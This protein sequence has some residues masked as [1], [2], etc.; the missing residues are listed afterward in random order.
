[1]QLIPVFGIFSSAYNPNLTFRE[2][3]AE[4]FQQ[5]LQMLA[6]RSMVR[7]DHYFFQGIASSHEALLRTPDSVAGSNQVAAC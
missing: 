4:Q 3:A 5:G 6:R 1:M 2:K 7:S